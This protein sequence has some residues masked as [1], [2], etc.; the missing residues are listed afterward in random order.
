MRST[1]KTK[2]T[3]KKKKKKRIKEKK[4]KTKGQFFFFFFFLITAE[5]EMA[6]NLQI[7]HMV[8]WSTSYHESFPQFFPIF[9]EKIFW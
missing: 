9:W 6:K 5:K 4:H 2:K 3:K 1:E 7:V 8:F